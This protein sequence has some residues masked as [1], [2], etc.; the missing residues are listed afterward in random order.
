[1]KLWCAE[2]YLPLQMK[3]KKKIVL[4]GKI[5]R[6]SIN[7]KNLLLSHNVSQRQKGEMV[8]QISLKDSGAQNW[9]M[10]TLLMLIEHQGK[11]SKAKEYYNKA[12]K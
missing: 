12:K 2:H 7:S 6:E 11:P 9:Q 10:K 1:M 5:T 3:K 4:S 8:S